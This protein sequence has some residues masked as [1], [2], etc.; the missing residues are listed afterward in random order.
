MDNC[1][2]Q[3]R[4]AGGGIHAASAMQQKWVRTIMGMAAAFWATGR[5]AFVESVE[6]TKEL[7][8]ETLVRLPRFEFT[9][10]VAAAVQ[11]GVW[12]RFACVGP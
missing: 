11:L 9:K 12:R 7:P 10:R 1:H 6:L 3:G 2:D 4:A 5:L 8:Q